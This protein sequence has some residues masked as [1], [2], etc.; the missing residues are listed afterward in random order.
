MD[1]INSNR[2]NILHSIPFNH[3]DFNLS[4][5]ATHKFISCEYVVTEVHDRVNCNFFGVKAV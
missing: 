1:K 4:I 3:K 5:I 2:H